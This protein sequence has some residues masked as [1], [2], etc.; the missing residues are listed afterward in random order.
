MVPK[1]KKI[2][3]WFILSVGLITNTV[4]NQKAKTPIFIKFKKYPFTKSF[5]WSVFRV[6]NLI[7]G[8]IKTKY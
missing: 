5:R 1:Y 7:Q 3:D 4:P 6:K 8:K 2:A